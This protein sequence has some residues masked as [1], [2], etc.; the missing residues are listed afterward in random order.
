M[1]KIQVILSSLERNKGKIMRIFIFSAIIKFYI[2][3]IYRIYSDQDTRKQLETTIN[4]YSLIILG[5]IFLNEFC[6]CLLP[7]FIVEN[8]KMITHFTGKGIIFILISIIFMNPLLGNQQNYS[9]YML[10]CVGILSILTD[11]KLEMSKSNLNQLIKLEKESP[12]IML[13]DIEN[14]NVHTSSNAENLT[15]E[16]KIEFS[17]TC[18]NKAKVDNPY[19]IPEDF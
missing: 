11:F 1:G 4:I 15:Q 18:A 19:D 9:G 16:V 2:S 8:F 7:K 14:G 17:E 13:T 5:V 10:F 3:A 12:R 6:K